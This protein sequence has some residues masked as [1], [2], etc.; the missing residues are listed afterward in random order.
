LSVCVV[1]AHC[2][3]RASLVLFPFFLLFL[4]Y[5]TR[6]KSTNVN[7]SQIAAVISLELVPTVPQGWRAL[8]LTA[9]GIS[10]CGACLCALLPESS[11]FTKVCFHSHS[12]SLNPHPCTLPALLHPRLDCFNCAQ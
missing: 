12:S 7:T 11:M 10:V 2:P 4:S 8:F 5:P 3:R 6:Y 1:G 9:S